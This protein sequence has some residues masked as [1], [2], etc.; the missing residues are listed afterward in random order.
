M[1]TYLSP[2]CPSDCSSLSL[3][4]NSLTT[5]DE[6]YTL[7]SSEI[8]FLYLAAKSED[9]NGNP[10]P[11]AKPTDWTSASDWAAVIGTTGDT[12]RKFEV[13]GDKP[14]TEDQ[15]VALPG[16]RTKIQQRTHTIN[17]T[18]NDMNSTNYTFMNTLAT[19][20]GTVFVNFV[21]HGDYMYGSSVD[22]LFIAN[23]RSCTLV[24]E[25]GEGS[26]ARWDLVLEWQ[27]LAQPERIASPI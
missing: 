15:E 2:S 18:V 6:N 12:V 17:I 23:V 11:V 1:S 4:D 25:R 26:N 9:I 8:Q 7:E 3:P 13:I 19:C 20:G 14:A 5:C 22:G 24:L 16:F 10:V 21:T 27:G